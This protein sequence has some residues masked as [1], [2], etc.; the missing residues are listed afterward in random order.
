[1]TPTAQLVQQIMSQVIHFL[2][3]T[4][5]FL[6][7]KWIITSDLWEKTSGKCLE[8]GVQTDC[9]A[10]LSA[11][12]LILKLKYN[13][14]FPSPWE[15]HLQLHLAQSF[16]R[17]SGAFWARFE[18]D[19]CEVYNKS[20]TQSAALELWAIFGALVLKSLQWKVALKSFSETL[21]NFELFFG[22]TFAKVTMKSRALARSQ[23]WFFWILQSF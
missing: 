7:Y 3:L 23:I 14:I 9:L 22:T 20:S 10:Q 6:L 5:V 18:Y 15:V 8:C 12:Y 17:V 21:I 13:E 16:S 19:F 4:I 11:P 1:M 2:C